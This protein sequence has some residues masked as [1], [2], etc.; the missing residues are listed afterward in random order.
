ML[1]PGQ[2]RPKAQR[3]ADRAKI[4]ELRLKGWTQQQ[5]AQA[6]D[7]S[8]RT[9]IREL[10]I[11]HRQWREEASEDIAAI[12]AR[13]LHKLDRMESEA[14]REWERSRVPHRKLVMEGGKVTRVEKSGQTGDPRY[15]Q[16]IMGIQ[17][18]RSRLLGLDAPVKFAP[19][20][21][22]GQGLNLRV[23][24]GGGYDLSQLTDPELLQ[25]RDLQTKARRT[26]PLPAEAPADGATA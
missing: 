16:A 7:I 18:R 10:E 15:L 11:L 8:L 5:I 2:K 24:D 12:K 13:E 17:D 19:T 9:C 4:A 14:W 6:V 26:T 20:T 22:E 23:H 3:L 25:L 21:P 1:T